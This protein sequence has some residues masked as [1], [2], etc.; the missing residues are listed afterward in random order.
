MPQIENLMLANHCEAQNG[1]L[2]LSGAGWTE[3]FR[4]VMPGQAVPPTH[5]GIGLSVLVGWLETDMVH[6]VLVYI[7]PEDSG[8]P[9]LRAEADLEIG[10]PEGLPEGIE[11]RASLAISGEVHFP[12]PGGYRLVC[13]LGENATRTVSF[14]V[15]DQVAV[16]PA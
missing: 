10:R 13:E 9:V 5:L 4:T 6:H 12:A 8:E 14:R 1:L 7:E 15:H 3:V 16:T 11:Q 2:Y